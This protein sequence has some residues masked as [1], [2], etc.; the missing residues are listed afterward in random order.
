MILGERRL[1]VAF[2]RFALVLALLISSRSSAAEP[3]ADAPAADPSAAERAASG[4]P[5]PAE[6]SPWQAGPAQI[7]L[8]HDVMLALPA[9]YG[10]L[11]KEPATKVL[12]ANGSLYNDNLLGIVAG[13]D[14]N[15]EWFVVVRYDEEGY[16]KDDDE[17]DA[18]ELLSNMRE[19]NEEANEERKRRGFSPLTLDGWSDPPHYDKAKHQLVWALIV[20]DKDG[21]SVNYNTRVLGRRGF[22]S[23]NLVT[24]PQKLAE[25][26]P[27]GAAL[28]AGTSFKQGARYGDF[29]E[30]T[31]KVA[32]YGLAGLV[33]A[34]AGLSAAKAIKLGLFAKFWKVILGVLIAGKKLV[35]VAVAA[36]GVALKRFFGAKNDETAES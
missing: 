1:I 6:P 18:D 13:A 14:Q 19:G 30:S 24:D 2:L 11:P 4:E 27:Y 15:A 28:L 35:V 26:K 29:N 21:K 9:Q 10:F 32:E 34:G 3:E 31:D 8:G 22:V 7:D 20:S 36:L 23:V 16:I 17:I 12:E 33:A 5:A 25:H